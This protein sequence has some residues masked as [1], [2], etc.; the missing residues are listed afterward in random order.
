MFIFHSGE[1][2]Q[3]E[4]P[5]IEPNLAVKKIAT[6]ET[7]Q[8]DFK[9]NKNQKNY[10]YFFTIGMATGLISKAMGLVAGRIDVLAD[11]LVC[12]IRLDGVRG[13]FV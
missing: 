13:T 10:F 6:E 11:R 1:I 4:S 2:D 8:T 3:I 12:A 5:I 7:C 9:E